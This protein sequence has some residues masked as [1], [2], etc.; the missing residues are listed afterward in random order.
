VLVEQRVAQSARLVVLAQTAQ[1]LRLVER[2]RRDEVWPEAGEARV[3]AD[4]RR[5]H[6]LEHRTVELDDLVVAAA[7]D[8]PGGPRR[9]RPA[10]A[11]TQ[12]A[13]RARHP[14]V[15]VDD[16]PALEA[17]KQVLADRL[18]EID[19]AAG[20]ALGPAVAAV[21]RVRRLE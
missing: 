21:A 6:Q 15:R 4:T 16:Q 11:G 12:D 13:P 9:A 20:E 14:Q 18:H 8:Q 10:L 3:G 2:R 7:D 5:C 19:A 1:V 17:E